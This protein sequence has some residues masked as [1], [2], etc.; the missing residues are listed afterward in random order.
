MW[1]VA[2]VVSMF[3]SGRIDLRPAWLA[4]KASRVNSWEGKVQE[5]AIT[6]QRVARIWWLIVW[7][8]SVGGG[9]LGFICGGI[10]GA[11]VGGVEGVMGASREALLSASRFAGSVAGVLASLSWGF[12]V[13]RM[14]LRK[15]YS[16]F[17]LA[18]VPY[19]SK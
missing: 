1:N 2:D 10:A 13:V 3:C 19:D 16:D 9:V 5:L 6:W 18:L 14:A 7:R 11:V 12:F 15:H 17:R 4:Q 8:A